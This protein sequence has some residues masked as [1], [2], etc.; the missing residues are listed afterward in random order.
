MRFTELAMG[1]HALELQASLSGLPGKFHRRQIKGRDYWYF[2]YRDIDG[3]GRILQAACLVKYFLATGRQAEFNAAW[4]DALA[5]GKGWQ[6]RVRQGQK[7]LLRG[8][9]DLA[10]KAL[11]HAS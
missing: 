9:P 3:R 7:A 11:W 5:R 4:R 10:D 8:A 1:A 2:G 6:A